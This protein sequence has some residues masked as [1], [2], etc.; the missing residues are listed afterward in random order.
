MLLQIASV[1]AST[2]GSIK[3]VSQEAQLL[4]ETAQ[5]QQQALGLPWQAQAVANHHEGLYSA[6]NPSLQL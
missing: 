5:S 1:A 2:E 6:L 3:L 4:T